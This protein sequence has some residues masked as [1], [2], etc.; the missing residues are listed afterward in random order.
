MKNWDETRCF[1]R[2]RKVINRKGED[3]ILGQDKLILLLGEV[4][5]GLGEF[6]CSGQGKM[7]RWDRRT[8]I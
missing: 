1:V 6:D 2:Q 7:I 3:I 5:H 8:C 4:V